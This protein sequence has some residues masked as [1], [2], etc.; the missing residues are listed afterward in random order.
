MSRTLLVPVDGS[1]LSRQALEFALEEYD[2]VSIVALH[3]IDPSEPGY[4]SMTEIDVRT[5]PPHGSEEWYERAGKEEAQIFEDA[6]EVT[7]EYDAAL[8][9]E[10]VVGDPAREIVDYAEEHDIDQIVLGGHGRTGATRLLLGSV[11]E[12]VV[13]RAP[14]TVTVVRNE[15][16][17]T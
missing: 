6:R 12:T 4:S 17:R 15:S 14:V 16:S 7:S 2:D 13:Y 3:V 10:S 11:A 9:T 8:E 5:E 1:P